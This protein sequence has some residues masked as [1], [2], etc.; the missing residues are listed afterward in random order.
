MVV[1]DDGIAV[2]VEAPFRWATLL[3]FHH[4]ACSLEATERCLRCRR[5]RFAQ[6]A[7]RLIQ[8]L[9]PPQS[10]AIP[11]R[12]FQPF[13]PCAPVPRPTCDSFDTHTRAQ[14][15]RHGHGPIAL[16]LEVLIHQ[17]PDIERRRPGGR[18]LGPLS[19]YQ[20]EACSGSTPAPE[21]LNVE[22]RL[23]NSS[24]FAAHAASR[25]CYGSKL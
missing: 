23:V 22:S 17:A 1:N 13:A 16:F 15:A 8:F 6:P 12:A 3:E 10:S 21:G 24:Q 11:E 25:L 20:H 7:V 18:A 4:L 19:C 14:P 5:Q 2:D 9:P